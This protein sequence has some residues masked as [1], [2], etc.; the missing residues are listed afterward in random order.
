VQYITLVN[1]YLHL[2]SMFACAGGINSLCNDRDDILTQFHSAY[3]AFV[4]DYVFACLK[5][6]HNLYV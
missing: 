1:C 5:I 6:M 2:N 3:D 4:I